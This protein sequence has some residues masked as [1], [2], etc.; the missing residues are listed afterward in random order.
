MHEHVN[1]PLSF[2]RQ[3]FG[4]GACA[5]GPT[6]CG[7]LG[8][9]HYRHRQRFLRSHWPRRRQ[10]DGRTGRAHHPVR[11]RSGR[12]TARSSRSSRAARSCR[13]S[14]LPRRPKDRPASSRS[15]KSGSSVCFLGTRLPLSASSRLAIRDDGWLLR[16]LDQ[17]PAHC[18]VAVGAG[19][20][21]LPFAQCN[22]GSPAVGAVDA[23]RGTRL[24]GAWH[25][26]YPSRRGHCGEPMQRLP[27]YRPFSTEPYDAQRLGIGTLASAVRRMES[28]GCADGQTHA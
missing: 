11:D 7:W 19:G 5:F 8:G 27:Y 13:T 18:S 16:R 21:R 23:G 3:Q 28:V 1:Q 6:L 22:L 10:S 20:E 26:D 12:T 2:G 17:R 25:V 24:S 14:R 15:S 4:G 9:L